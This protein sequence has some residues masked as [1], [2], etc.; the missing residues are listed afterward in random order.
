MQI[1]YDHDAD[2]LFRPEG[3]AALDRILTEVRVNREG[4][5]FSAGHAGRGRWGGG[6]PL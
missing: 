2:A 5:V 3:L 1:S 4:A 6:V